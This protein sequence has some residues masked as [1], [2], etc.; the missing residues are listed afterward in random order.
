MSHTNRRDERQEQQRGRYGALAAHDLDQL[1]NVVHDLNKLSAPLQSHGAV[2]HTVKYVIPLA[3][4]RWASILLRSVKRSL[5]T[6]FMH[7]QIYTP[8][9]V[10]YLKMC[11]VSSLATN[12]RESASPLTRDDWQ[13]R[14]LGLPDKEHYEGRN[15]QYERGEHSSTCPRVCYT[16][17]IQTQLCARC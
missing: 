14:E 13:L 12:Q 17:P 11:T 5:K 1:R 15:A 4:R 9:T 7:V 16:A 10:R 8:T 6:H 2:R 3:K